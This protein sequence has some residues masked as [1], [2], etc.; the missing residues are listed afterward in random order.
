MPKFL[1]E[2]SYTSE[3]AKGLLKD[4]GT[5]RRAAAKAAA[6]SVGGTLESMYYAFGKNDAVL[7][8]D[9]PDTAAAAALAITLAASGAVTNRTTLLLSVEDIDA[10]TKRAPSY[11]PPGR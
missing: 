11:T 9:F 2:V 1:M 3:G 6:E 8:A 5:K 7:I 10:A 4:G